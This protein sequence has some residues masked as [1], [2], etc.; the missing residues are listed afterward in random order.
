MWKANGFPFGK[1]ATFM[2]GELAIFCGLCYYPVVR[3]E[4]FGA[5]SI[6]ISYLLNAEP[7]GAMN[8]VFQPHV[9]LQLWLAWRGS[10]P[11]DWWSYLLERFAS[12]WSSKQV[13]LR[14]MWT[15]YCHTC[16]WGDT[17]CELNSVI[18]PAAWPVGR[19]QDPPVAELPT[20]WIPW[21]EELC[22]TTQVHLYVADAPLF[23]AL[24]SSDWWENQLVK[25]GWVIVNPQLWWVCLSP[26]K[27][28]AWCCSRGF[29]NGL[30]VVFYVLQFSRGDIYIYTY[31]YIYDIGWYCMLDCSV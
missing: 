5:R 10:S 25:G 15:T 23:R 29:T 12:T 28:T 11:C 1:W 8:W 27:K 17:D 24:A 7:V 22:E 3:R 20:H 30:F 16:I 6:Y 9:S 18:F 14:M 26:K 19:L 13:T 4:Q 21:D 31:I 2:V